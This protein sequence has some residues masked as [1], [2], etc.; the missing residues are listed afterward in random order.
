MCTG[1]P[2]V[3]IK[4][5]IFVGPQMRELIKDKSFEEKL[6]EQVKLAWKLLNKRT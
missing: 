4:Q 6:D 3:Q 5:G 2:G 1:S